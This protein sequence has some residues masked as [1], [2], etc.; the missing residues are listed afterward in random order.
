MVIKDKNLYK[1]KAKSNKNI[2]LK[3]WKANFLF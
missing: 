3:L 1:L 2:K